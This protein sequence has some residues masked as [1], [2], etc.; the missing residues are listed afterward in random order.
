[1]N[2]KY[3]D[4]LEYNKILDKFKF[5]QKEKF[6]NIREIANKYIETKNKG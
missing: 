4:K 1:M 5:K 6:E 2:T 3:L